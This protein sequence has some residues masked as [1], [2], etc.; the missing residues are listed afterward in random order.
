MEIYIVDVTYINNYKQFQE[1]EL[2]GKDTINFYFKIYV[3]IGFR[4]R[5]RETGKRNINDRETL[6]GCLCMPPTRDLPCNLDVCPNWDSNWR[7]LG[8]WV[9]DKPT[10]P[11]QPGQL[12][13][14]NG[15]PPMDILCNF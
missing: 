3:F 14:F 2:F 4:K 6:I 15:L 11:Q 1:I 12:L 7:P 13:L 5:E 10:E 8:G 9:D